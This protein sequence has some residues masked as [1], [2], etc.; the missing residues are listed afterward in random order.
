MY[1]CMYVCI[2]I[3]NIFGFLVSNLLSPVSVSVWISV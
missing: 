1:V 3:S 2:Q